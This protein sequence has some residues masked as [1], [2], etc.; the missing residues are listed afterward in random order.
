[1]G[2]V[3]KVKEKLYRA[4]EEAKI[5]KE[6]RTSVKSRR[7]HEGGRS[8]QE[9][10]GNIPGGPDAPRSAYREGAEEDPAGEVPPP[11]VGISEEVVERIARRVATQF[12][13]YPRRAGAGPGGSKY[14]HW[15]GLKYC[16][17]VS[18][19]LSRTL[20]GLVTEDVPDEVQEAFLV[21]RLNGI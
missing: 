12:G 19:S 3:G 16:E 15:D 13:R 2:R 21:A 6:L 11:P 9:E 7:R 5:V 1:M 17:E 18:V 8:P 10:D 4:Q 14:E 20:L